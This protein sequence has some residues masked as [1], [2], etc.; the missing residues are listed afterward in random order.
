MV[1]LKDQ[2]SRI[3]LGSIEHAIDYPDFLGV[4]AD[5]FK[6]FFQLDTPSEKSESQSL[7]IILFISGFLLEGK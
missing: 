1:K 2:L 4:Q 7:P 5:S 6:N 3:N